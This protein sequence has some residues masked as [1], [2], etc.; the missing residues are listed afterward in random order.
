[1][2]TEKRILEIEKEIESLYK[3][4]EEQDKKWDFSK[5]FSSYEKM[6]E[7]EVKRINVLNREKRMIMIPEFEELSDYGDVMSLKEFIKEVKEGSFIDY[8][9]NG[10]YVKDNKES[11]IKIYPSDVDHN[12]IRKDFDTIIWFNR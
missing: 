9:G 12:S 1:M 5:D 11:N 10:N 7:K 2:E 4:L 8:D 6:R 3:T